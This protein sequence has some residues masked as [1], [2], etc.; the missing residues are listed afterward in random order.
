MV[1]LT[2]G[3][4]LLVIP[5][6]PIRCTA[7]GCTRGDAGPAPGVPSQRGFTGGLT[8]WEIIA[9]VLA[10]GVILVGFLHTLV[11]HN[12]SNKRVSAPTE[13]VSS[14]VE[15]STAEDH[16][17]HVSPNYLGGNPLSDGR[18]Y[19]IALVAAASEIPVGTRLFAQGRVRNYGYAGMRSRPFAV[20]E[21]EQQPDKMLFCGM[22]ADEG[23][24]VL[25]LYQQGEIVQVFG[26]YLGTFAVRRDLVANATG[27]QISMPTLSDCKVAGPTDNVVR[28]AQAPGISP[29]VN[30]ADDSG[31]SSPEKETTMPAAD[32]TSVRSPVAPA[33]PI[34]TP[35]PLTVETQ[36]AAYPSKLQFEAGARLMIHVNSITRQPDGSFTFRGTLLLPVALTGAVSLD[37]NTKLA[38]SG[39]AN[40]RTASVTGFTVN[41]EDYGLQAANGSNKQPG[42]GP[43]VQLDPGKVLE[44]W[45]ASPS[46][47][48][49]T[50]GV[51]AQ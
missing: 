24:E 10:G 27:W 17:V 31:L 1:L 43:A 22:M 51:G 8:P 13:T 16:N 30:A 35:A 7:C 40:G 19:S 49:K 9:L 29:S 32:D 48:E 23:A 4:W 25:S 37:Q 38:G 46:V 2:F 3:L 42:S 39:A 34:E 6:Y 14:Q 47:Y 50:T 41:G 28:P 18:T 12:S 11:G 5:F 33:V 44:M 26:E 20:I 36:S 21:D 45:F 15:T